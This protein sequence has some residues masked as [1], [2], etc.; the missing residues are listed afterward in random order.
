MHVFMNVVCKFEWIKGNLACL[1]A[2]IYVYMY[3]WMHVCM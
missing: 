1:H 2:C 3:E